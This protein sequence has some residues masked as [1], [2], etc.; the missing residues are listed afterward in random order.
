MKISL[1]ILTMNEIVGLREIL[2]KIPRN[3]VDEIFAVDGGSTDGTIEFFKSHKIPVYFQEVRGRGE[4]FRVAFKKA[5]GDAL[6]L[7]S[8]DGNE[9]PGDIPKFR[10]LLEQGYDLVIATRMTK[11]AHNE[12][13]EQFFKLRK[14][15]NNIFTLVANIIWNRGKYVTD[16]INGYRAITKTAWE[17]LALD[18]S[19]YTIEYQGSIRAFKLGLKII[20]FPTYESG[21]IDNGVGS[22]SLKTGIEF[23]KLF[24]RELI[25]GKKGLHLTQE[26]L[27]R[28]KEKSLKNSFWKN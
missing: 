6:I 10:P 22:P 3:Q 15:V 24:F 21:R 13:D 14:W 12:E 11:E 27:Q 17:R 19:G 2:G 28:K 8:P 7:F 9:D 26:E 1:V 23:L 18:G 25:M 20:E 4:A 5:K 16:T